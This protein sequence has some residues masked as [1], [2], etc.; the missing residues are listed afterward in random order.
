M[1]NTDHGRSVWG[2][3]VRRILVVAAI[4]AATVIGASAIA[5]AE[6]PA[7][8]ILDSPCDAAAVGAKKAEW[9]K[10]LKREAA[11][12]N[13]IGMSF[14]LIPPGEFEMGSPAAEEG[15]DENEFQHTVRITQPF[16]PGKHTVRV[17]DF[18]AFVEAEHYKT[19]VETSKRGYG[20]VDEEFHQDAK[21]NWRNPGYDQT[22]DHPVVNVTWEDASAFCRWLGKKEKRTCRLPTEAEWEYACRAGT[23][24]VFSFGDSCN[25][26]EA[27]CDGNLYPYGTK[28]KGPGLKHPCKVGAYAAN[29]FG[30]YDMHGNVWQWCSDWYGQNYYGRSPLE[31]PQ[32]PAEGDFRI[33]RGG[34]WEAVPESCRAARRQPA[35]AGLFPYLA[36]FRVVYEL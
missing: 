21:Y 17:Q 33:M 32:G 29:A 14:A 4:A 27:N 3:R 18:R 28:T 15:R 20:V 23:T 12:K 1:T 22:D 35:V 2:R 16:Y 9:A 7:P 31:N 6:E 24:T 25:G 11:E 34:T 13:S 5:Q 30:L 10:H 26:T 8:A 19:E 36:G